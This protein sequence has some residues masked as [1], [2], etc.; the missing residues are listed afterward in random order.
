MAET[1]LEYRIIAG[2]SYLFWPLSV[3]IVCTGYKKDRFLRF[4]GYQGLYFGIC[5][6]VGYLVIGGFLQIIP[7]IGVLISKLLVLIWFLCCLFLFWRCWRGER[8][9]I[10][11]VSNLAEGLM[12]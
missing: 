7:V 1:T 3:L 2:I 9:K 5:C 6:A 4:H 10:P 11:I 12:E 8:F